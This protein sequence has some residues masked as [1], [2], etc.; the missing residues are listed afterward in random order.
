MSKQ[1]APDIDITLVLSI[2][3]I[4]SIAA[5]CSAVSNDNRVPVVIIVEPGEQGRSRPP[6]RARL[7]LSAGV[8]PLSPRHDSETTFPNETTKLNRGIFH[9]LST[10]GSVIYLYRPL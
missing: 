8:I 9:F 6:P 4:R 5:P 7:Y 10:G 2:R 3:A 1:H